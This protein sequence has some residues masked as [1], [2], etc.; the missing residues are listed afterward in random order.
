M[1]DENQ[2]LI[3]VEFKEKLNKLKIL[4]N[5]IENHNDSI[6]LNELNKSSLLITLSYSIQS[7]VFISLNLSNFNIQNHNVLNELVSLFIYFCSC[8]YLYSFSFSFSFSF[9][10]ATCKVIVW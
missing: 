7:L 10:I 3:L 2:N 4:L 5:T 6:N 1:E 8:L 9:S